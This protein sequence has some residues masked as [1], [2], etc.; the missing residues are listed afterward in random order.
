MYDN[1]EATI[2][3]DVLTRALRDQFM[4]EDRLSKLRSGLQAK[5]PYRQGR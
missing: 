2:L 5:G 3:S 4:T 1:N